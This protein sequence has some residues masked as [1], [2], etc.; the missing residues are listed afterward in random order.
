MK[1]V[2]DTAKAD[3]YGLRSPY[4]RA[5]NPGIWYGATGD[6]NKLLRYIQTHESAHAM[7]IGTHDL[8][9]TIMFRSIPVS[10]VN[11]PDSGKVFYDPL[12]LNDF[13]STSKS[14][15]SVKKEEA[16]GREKH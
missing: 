11:S 1:I 12:R 10:P 7:G 16:K 4:Y 15:T 9:K 2:V 5:P 8:L 3:Y 6:F 14:Q 13:S